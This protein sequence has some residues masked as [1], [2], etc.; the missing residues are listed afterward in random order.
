MA[1]LSISLQPSDVYQNTVGNKQDIICSLSVPPNMDPDT[2]ELGWLNEDDIVTDDG[3]VTIDTSS[4]YYNDS[5]LLTIIRFN[6]LF[7]NDEG[8]YICYAI[9]N[10]SFVI[11]PINL[12][13]FTSNS[14][15]VIMYVYTYIHYIAVHVYMYLNQNTFGVKKVVAKN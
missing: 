7:E 10:N 12:Q 6:S 8:E 11:E 13:N 14:I 9:I 15:Y 1:F 5:S 3:R 4:D 2:F